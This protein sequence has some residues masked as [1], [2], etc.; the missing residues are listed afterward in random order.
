MSPSK[1]LTLCTTFRGD[2]GIKLGDNNLSDNNYHV[3]L[4]LWG[5]GNNKEKGELI[6][7]QVLCHVRTP[8]REGVCEC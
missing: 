4:L 3:E 7:T 1:Y 8:H 6:K 2:L 5:L